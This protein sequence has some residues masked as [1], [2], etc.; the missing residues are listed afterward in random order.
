M[1]PPSQPDLKLPVIARRRHFP[2]RVRLAERMTDEALF[3]LCQI[4][5]DLQIERAADGEL[6]ITS[7]TGGET[8]RRNAAIVGAMVAWA[9][10]DAVGIVF[11]SNGGFV[12][13]NGAERAPDA[14]WVGKDRWEALSREERERFPPLCPDFVVELRSPSDALDELHAKMREYA[15]NGAR[16]GWLLDPESRRVWV[17]EGAREPVCL[18]DPATV[19][20]EPVLPG[21]SLTLASIW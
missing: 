18:E 16:L 21:F 2:L 19:S 5:R 8:S 12:L 20:G 10:K 9:T 15:A 4:N 1:Q 13:P 14:S 11:D 3:D 17:Y 7:S 6:I